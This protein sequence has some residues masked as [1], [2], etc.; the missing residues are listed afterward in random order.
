[1]KQRNKCLRQQGLSIIEIILAMA[2]FVIIISTS[3]AV[4]IHSFSANRLAVEESEAALLASEGIEAIRSIKNQDFTNLISGTY[5]VTSSQGF[6]QLGPTPTPGGKYTRTIT[7]ADVYRDLSGEIVEVGGALDEETKKATSLV[8][9]LFSPLRQNMI[10]MVTYFANWVSTI[11]FWND[12]DIVSSGNTV[13]GSKKISAEARDVFVTDG[14]AY[15]VSDYAL[16][17]RPEFFI[18]DTTNPSGELEIIGSLNLD[19]TINAV[20]VSGD[21][22]YLATN[23]ENEELVVINISDPSNPQKVGDY[24][25]DPGDWLPADGMDVWVDET[26][27]YLS[28]RINLSSGIDPEFYVLEVNTSDPYNVTFSTLGHLDIDHSINGIYIDGNYAYLATAD[29]NKE[30]QIAD[31]SNPSNPQRV[32]WYDLEEDDLFAWA[33]SVYVNEGRAY[34]ATQKTGNNDEYYVLEL[35]PPYDSCPGD[36]ESYINQIASARLNADVNDV[37][38]YE[39]YVFTASEKGNEELKVASIEDPTN[40]LLNINMGSKAYAVYVY[41]CSAYVATGNNDGELQVVQPK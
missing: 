13:A 3:A 14:Y 17:D 12:Y 32:C 23:R 27:V 19:T 28:T 31:V 20:Y 38:V 36:P 18:F 40:F 25:A 24:D 2:I 9:W 11:C 21:F 41:Q 5:D 22:A 29:W 33:N 6:W 30:F 34:L 16:F 26:T 1:M 15:L 4:I 8:S 7:I 10:E 37:F 35:H 39:G